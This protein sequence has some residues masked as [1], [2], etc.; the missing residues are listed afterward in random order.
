MKKFTLSAEKIQSN[1]KTFR[2]IINDSFPNRKDQMNKLYDELEER[3]VMAPASSIDYFHNAFPGGYVDHVLRVYE[4]SLKLYKLWA[5]CGL[6]TDNFSIE[7]LKF[8]SI[9][10]DIGKLGMPG[11]NRELYQKNPS[12]WHV[13]NQGKVYQMNPEVPFME[14]TDR[15]FYL[16]N[17]YGIRYSENEQAGIQLCDGLYNETNK[18]Y[19]VSFDVDKK[20]KTSIGTI[21]H[22]ADMMACRFEFE[23]WATF[24]NRFQFYTKKIEHNSSTLENVEMPKSSS[25]DLFDK[26]F[27]QNKG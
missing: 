6:I 8:V 18:P 2:T 19:L 16:L 22:H 5:D 3:T 12:D 11:S 14:T 1:W 21:M 13:K 15:T 4:I 24:E 9:N 25:L 26:M 20:Q 10:H 23:R 17:H 7:E 27:P